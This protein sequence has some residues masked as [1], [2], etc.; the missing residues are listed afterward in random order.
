MG[1]G[2]GGGGAGVVAHPAIAIGKNRE[3]AAGEI[4]QFMVRRRLAQKRLLLSSRQIAQIASAAVRVRARYLRGRPR[5]SRKCA[6]VFWRPGRNAM[7]GSHP[8]TFFASSIFGLRRT[9]SS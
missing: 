4:F 7:C 8:R 6:I 9:G 1:A 3:N 2:A 5:T